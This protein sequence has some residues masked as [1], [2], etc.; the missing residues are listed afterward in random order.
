MTLSH[1]AE[2]SRASRVGTAEGAR[3][4]KGV[5]LLSN[6]GNLGI[7]LGVFSGIRNQRRDV[8]R[9]LSESSAGDHNYCANRGELVRWRAWQVGTV[10]YSNPCP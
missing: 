4:K 10:L 2:C 1:G 9:G 3:K 7:A 5:P 8:C 6:T